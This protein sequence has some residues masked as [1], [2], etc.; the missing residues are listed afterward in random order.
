MYM[1]TYDICQ[2]GNSHL[3]IP[4]RSIEREVTFC[5]RGVVSPLLANVYLHYVFDC[6]VDAW[7]QT[8]ATG[9]VSVVRYADDR[10]PRRRREEARM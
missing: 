8:V 10:A 5:V 4:H 3:S 1:T 9:D 2:E 6:W 7:R